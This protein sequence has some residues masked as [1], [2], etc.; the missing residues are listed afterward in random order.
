MKQTKDELANDK[1]R[2]GVFAGIRC[3]TNVLLQ[4]P[5]EKWPD[6]IAV[7]EI[8]LAT[9]QGQREFLEKVAAIKETGEPK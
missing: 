9:E 4:I 7:I 2:R 3:L 8:Q 6:T 1:W 5:V